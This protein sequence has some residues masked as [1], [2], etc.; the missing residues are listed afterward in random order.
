M[1]RAQA[2]FTLADQLKARLAK[3]FRGQ[4]VA[5]DPNDQPASVLL[6]RFRAARQADAGAG[7]PSRRGRRKAATHPAPRRRS[8]APVPSDHLARLPRARGALSERTWL[9]SSELDPAAFQVPLR[10]ELASGHLREVLD[11]GQELLEAEP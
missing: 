11:N 3:A 10:A 4:Q 2:L 1:R 7:T 5:Q 8:A 9:A 6:K